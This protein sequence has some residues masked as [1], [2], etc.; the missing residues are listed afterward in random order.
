MN[1]EWT[2]TK[3]YIQPVFREWRVSDVDL[4]VSRGKKKYR[5]FCSKARVDKKSLGGTF[6]LR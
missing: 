4:F 1:Q 5:M 6:Q 3:L 2:V